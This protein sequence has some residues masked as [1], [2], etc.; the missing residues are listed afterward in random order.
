LD[1]EIGGAIREMTMRVK[2]NVAAKKKKKKKIANSWSGLGI[3]TEERG[4]ATRA[5]GETI[6]RSGKV[7]T[8]CQVY[9]IIQKGFDPSWIMTIKVWFGGRSGDHRNGNSKRQHQ[10]DKFKVVEFS[11]V[12]VFSPHPSSNRG[13]LI[14]LQFAS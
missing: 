5:S 12:S 2:C 1:P 13:T 8:I 10:Q 4:V 7:D 14:V 3:D 6:P 9:S 11:S